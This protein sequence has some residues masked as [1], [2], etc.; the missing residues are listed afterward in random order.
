MEDGTQHAFEVV[1]LVEDDE[2]NAYAVCYNDK[3]DEF[4]VTDQFGELLDD[5]DLAQEILDDF[6]VLAEESSPP[7]E[8]A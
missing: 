4:V 1:G 6:F 3:A 2:N 8:P 5:D 7:E